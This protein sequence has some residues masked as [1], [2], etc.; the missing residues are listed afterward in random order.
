MLPILIT[1]TAMLVVSMIKYSKITNMMVHQVL[2]DPTGTE[3]T[4]VYKNQGARR[5]RNDKPEQ[6]MMIAQ[7]V[8]PPQGPDFKPLS[9]DLFPTEY[10]LSE[11]D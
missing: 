3:L 10:P 4:F 1:A 7:L 2:L 6:T 11:P 8:D 5:L 9:G